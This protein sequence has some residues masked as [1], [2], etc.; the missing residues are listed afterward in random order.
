MPIITTKPTTPARRQSTYLDNSA[1]DKVR[2]EKSL[3]LPKNRINGR[4]H[5]GQIV[6]YHRGGGAKRMYRIIDFVG[7]KRL[8]QVATVVSLQYDP[9]RTANIALIQFEDK[10]KAYIIAPDGLKKEMTVVCDVSA[11]SRIGNRMQLRN[12][13]VATQIHSIELVAG[14][15][16]QLCRSAGSFATLLGLDSEEGRYALLRLPSGEVRKVIADNY[17]SIGIVSNIDHSKVVLGNA[18]RKRFMGFRP[19]VLGKS[20]NAVDHPHGGGEGHSPIGC[21]KGPKTPWGAL[22]L[23]PRTRNKKKAGAVLILSRRKK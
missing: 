2:P 22:A 15:G 9:N 6:V 7:T 13:P 16:S 5:A 4:N 12:I 8:G 23:G 20:K 21:K 1:L 3:T 19:T 18:G 10:T 17:A 14:K 11:P